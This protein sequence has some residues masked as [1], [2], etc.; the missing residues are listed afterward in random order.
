MGI[1]DRF[2]KEAKPAKDTDKKVSKDSGVKKDE[3]KEK[4][5]APKPAD[6]KPSDKKGKSTQAYRILVKP[7]ITEKASELGALNKY[8]F[9]VNPKMNKIEIKK[10]I[11]TVYNV[12]P[13]S[14]NILNFSG[15]KVRYGRVQGRTKAWKKAIVTLKPGD[16]IEVYEGV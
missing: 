14:V 7:L 4:K 5:A 11:K 16:T 13:I 15:K 9:A 10:A 8:A 12:E 2:K 6:K 1:L 3:P